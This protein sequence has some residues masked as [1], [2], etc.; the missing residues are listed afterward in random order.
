[1]SRRNLDPLT[2]VVE[3]IPKTGFERYFRFPSGQF[4]KPC[5]IAT[6]LGHIGRAHPS[7]VVFDR[8]ANA[9]E[10]QQYLE[11]FLY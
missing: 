10:T 3:D 8:D 2:P 4:T 7:W 9:A 5:G 11:Q 6:N 1:M